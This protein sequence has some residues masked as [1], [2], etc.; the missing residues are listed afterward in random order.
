[1]QKLAPGGI[2]ATQSGCAAIHDCHQGV[3][4]AVNNTLKQAFPL[5]LPYTCYVPSFNSEWGWNMAFKDNNVN[6]QE[7]F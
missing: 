6:P 2:F 5:V 3:F 1:M 4:T 7:R